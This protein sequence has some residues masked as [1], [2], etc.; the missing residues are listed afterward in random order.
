[1]SK[2]TI[3]ETPYYSCRQGELVEG[4]KRCVKGE[5]L[6]LFVTG[7]CPATCF[8]CPLSPE[9]KM[10]DVAFANE[11][12][13][14][15]T[16]E[17]Q[18]HLLIDEARASKA[19][20]AGITGGDPLARLGRT[21]DYIRELKRIFGKGFH[22]HL[23]T[24]LILVNEDSLRRL[25]EAGLDE[26]RFHP[27]LESEKYWGR[28]R[29]A[30]AYD[31][32]VGIEIPVLPDKVKESKRLIT[33]ALSNGLIDFLNLNELE[34]SELT[35]DTFAARGYEIT[36]VNSYGIKGSAE[37]AL[38]L[39][40]SASGIPVHF[41]TTRLKDRVQMGNRIL[42]RSTNDA[43]P[44][45]EI[46]DEGILTRGAIYISLPPGHGYTIRLRSMNDKEKGRDLATLKRIIAW[47]RKQDMPADAGS[48]DERRLRVVL[49]KDALLQL[50][51]PLVAAFPGAKPFI[52]SEYPTSDAWLVAVEPLILNTQRSRPRAR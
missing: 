38:D 14:T 39:M 34:I 24:P 28:M 26:I 47:L 50:A 1:M 46:D 51:K 20:G 35:V 30:R 23:Y 43:R 13:L 21:C 40:R 52:V 2:L 19:T 8:F 31:W 44:F 49:G 5:K 45:D 16:S 11:R 33:F 3:I 9:K 41:C 18:L 7:V 29:L 37:A 32:K 6:V 25:H 22:L 10:K 42:L 36:G 27:S 12:E 48:L 17:E 15:G 4:C